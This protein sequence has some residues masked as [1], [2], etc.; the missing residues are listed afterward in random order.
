MRASIA[1]I[2]LL[3]SLFS[4]VSHAQDM[5]QE[6]FTLSGSVFT[7]DNQPAGDTSIKVIPMESIWS[8]DGTY[9][10]DGISPGEHTVRAYFMNDGH[11]VV[12]RKISINSNLNLDWYVDKNWVTFEHNENQEYDLV[13][14]ELTETSE[15]LQEYSNLGEF[16]P[17]DIGGYYTLKAT[18]S[19]EIA[20]TQ[21][22]HFRMEPGSSSNP[23]PNHFQFNY[24]HNSVYGFMSDLDGIPVP[25]VTV[26]ANNRTSVTNSDGF[27]LLQNLEV[28][29][30]HS[31]TAKYW[32]NDLIEPIPMEIT[33]NHG[34]L[35]LTATAEKNMP[36][37]ANFSTQIIT[38]SLETIDVHWE[39]GNYTD[40]YSLFLEGELVYRGAQESY[41]FDPQEPGNYHFSVEAT[42]SN[43]SKMNPQ[44]LRVVVLPIQSNSDLWSTGMSWDYTILHTPYYQQ[45]KTY[46]AIG[47]ESIENAFGDVVEAYL[48][49]IS[50][51]DYEEGEK[52]FRWVDKNTLMTTH[53]YWVD[54]PSVSSY[55]QEGFLGWKFSD[56]YGNA[57]NPLLYSGNEEINLHFNRTNIIGVPGHPNGY[58]DTT[59]K[60]QITH[61]V[62]LETP[63]GVFKTT[64]LRI[65][66]DDDGV[67]S[68]EMWY[69]ETVRNWVKVIDRI[70][71]SHSDIVTWE[72]TSFEVPVTPQFLTED[73]SKF[74]D[75]DFVIEWANFQGA[76]YYQL[77][78]NGN[79]IYTGQD[80][81]I[82]L[83]D[84]VDGDYTYGLSA[85]M[86]TGTTLDGEP[87][88][89][90]VSFVLKPP[91]FLTDSHSVN[92]TSSEVSWSAVD[93]GPA[94]YT[95]LVLHGD[96]T[97][98]IAYE[99][100]EDTANIDVLK[101]GINRVRVMAALSDEVVSEY[102]D[103]IFITSPE[104]TEESDILPFQSSIA[105]L[106]VLLIGPLFARRDER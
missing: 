87:I 61:G 71:G 35:N 97:S 4:A 76:S 32:G 42:N 8:T 48:M 51:D 2:L 54:S 75:H 100:S 38:S 58:E 26:S 84:R 74:S 36:D 104:E 64:Y 92:G 30:T 78:E 102:S 31:I 23:N 103:S 41:V 94:Q 85:V 63:A 70:P 82:S 7:S 91:T 28:G 101:P 40:Y 50:D 81:N 73:N 79:L 15:V 98:S 65:T 88:N 43:G 60:V 14:M 83:S 86:E 53:T 55:Y 39:G 45:N 46:T 56:Q 6:S 77:T 1:A 9:S 96:G 59:N 33:N 47:S 37:F 18:Y 27:F 29:S 11:T 52:A 10:I 68:W 44:E 72:L 90:A 67:L 69:N 80:T 49:R 99:G 105:T 34:W 95:V 5:D 22:I 16:G 19:D 93:D 20:S 24:G 62:T 17:H 57:V 21:H 66:D 12:Y 106:V 3:S 89:V 13:S 25:D